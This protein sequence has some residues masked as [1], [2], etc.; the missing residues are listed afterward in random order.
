MATTPLLDQNLG[1]FFWLPVKGFSS[2]TL[3]LSARGPLFSPKEGGSQSSQ[4]PR[5]VGELRQSSTVDG[6]ADT[7]LGRC[8]VGPKLFWK[9]V[10]YG[11]TRNTF[12]RVQR[13]SQDLS[14]QVKGRISF[15]CPPQTSHL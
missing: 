6:S 15:V 8:R 3:V 14:V 2:F 5:K 1:T 13:L 7:C 12:P 4:E 9:A 11:G 10:T